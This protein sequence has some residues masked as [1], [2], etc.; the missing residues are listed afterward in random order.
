VWIHHSIIVDIMFE[1]QDML[2]HMEV[3]KDVQPPKNNKIL[4]GGHF[5]LKRTPLNWD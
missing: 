2:H 5:I 1:W 3:S 4:H